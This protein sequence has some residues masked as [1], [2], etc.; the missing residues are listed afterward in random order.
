MSEQECRKSISLLSS[1]AEE[2]SGHYGREKIASNSVDRGNAGPRLPISLE[3]SGVIDSSEPGVRRG[4]EREGGCPMKLLNLL[5]A[6]VACTVVVGC[7]S[8]Q[9]HERAL[10]D[11]ATSL[12]S[13]KAEL[14]RLQQALEE[15]EGAE[16]GRDSSVD[17]KRIIKFANRVEVY[18]VVFQT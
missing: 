16:E 12:V 18:V 17:N 5:L 1:G 7:V 14:E 13:T 8:Q 6:V 11:Y 9:S 4:G 10:Q 2:P 3:P 15:N